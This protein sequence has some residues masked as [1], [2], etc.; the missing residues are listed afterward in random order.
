MFIKSNSADGTDE[1]ARKAGAAVRYEY[2]QG[3]GN[4]IRSMFRDI[5][6]L[7]AF[8]SSPFRFSPKDL[9]YG[10]FQVNL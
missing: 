3:K 7:A 4:V 2:R 1:I 5:G 6:R 9:R 10:A 8:S